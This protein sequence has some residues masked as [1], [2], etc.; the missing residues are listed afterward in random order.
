MDVKRFLPGLFAL[1]LGVGFEGA[2]R[3]AELVVFESTMC[4]WCEVWQEEVGETYWKTSEARL[5]T[6][7]RIDIDDG[8]PGNLSNIANVQFTPT[9]VLV[10]DGKEIGR[11]VGYPGESFFWQLLSQLLNRISV[12]VGHTCAPETGKLNGGEKTC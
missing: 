11:I 10:K 6:L 7:R 2:S 3:A 12:D 1:L 9:F 8:I 4:E 5:A